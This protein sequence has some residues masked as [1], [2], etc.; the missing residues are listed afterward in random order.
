M[1]MSDPRPTY[2][3]EILDLG[4]EGHES[5]MSTLRSQIIAGLS[6]PPG[7]RT[8]PTEILYDERGLQLLDELTSNSK[9]YLAFKAE[10]EIVQTHSRE[11]VSA[12]GVGSNEAIVFELGAG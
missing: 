12:M 1:T 9:T 7:H 5:P 2:T 11:I 8:L 3:P 6:K 4:E 10:E